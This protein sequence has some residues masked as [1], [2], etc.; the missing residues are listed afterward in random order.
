[1]PGPLS[2]GDRGFLVELLQLFPSFFGGSCDIRPQTL[3]RWHRAGLRTIGVGKLGALGGRL[4]IDSD[5][6]ALIK[7]MSMKI[8]SMPSLADRRDPYLV[9]AV[10]E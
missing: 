1:M 10:R 7:K 2:N 3:L 8:R 5:F 6:R 4:Q 9:K